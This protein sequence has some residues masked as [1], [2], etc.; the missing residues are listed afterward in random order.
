MLFRPAPE[1]FFLVV[2]SASIFFSIVEVDGAKFQRSLG[3]DFIGRERQENGFSEDSTKRTAKNKQEREQLY[4]AYNMLHTLA[5]V[6]DTIHF[7]I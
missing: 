7:N 4:E 2:I 5:Q 1:I 3:T 6:I